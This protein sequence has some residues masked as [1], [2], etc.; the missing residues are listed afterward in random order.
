[1]KPEV[2]EQILIEELFKSSIKKENIAC[3]KLADIERLTG[4]ASTRKYYRVHC[5]DNSFVV[6]LD[7]P[8]ELNKNS[9][10]LIQRF[11]N[12]NGIRVPKIFDRNVEK[13]YLLEEDLGDE[14]LLKILGIINN[15]EQEYEIYKVIIDEL[16]KMHKLDREKLN[17]TII[18]EQSFDK[19]KLNDE[20][21][22]TLKYF[23]GKFLN[24]QDESI[25]KDIQNSFKKVNEEISKMPMVFTHRDF[26]SRNVMVKD[27]EYIVIDFQDAR[28]GIPQYDLVSL[29]EDC[30]YDL[31]ESNREKLKRYYFDEMDMSSLGQGGYDQFCY[32]YDLMLLQRVFKAV[33]SFSYIYEHR[34]DY[35]YV[36]Y[37]G[38]AME[39]L[40]R[41]MLRNSELDNLR[42]SLFNVYYE[43]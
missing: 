14:T 9:F 17:E 12:D 15:E 28:L 39:K 5:S 13:G 18:T 10:V 24:N 43:S 40:R 1:M 30:Y 20:I 29:L 3:S 16:L 35:R 31:T 36:K 2:S 41:T 19:K 38:F 7:N 11:L 23:L 4:D 25:F 37:I 34:K 22:F 33:G 6:C 26:H 21:E 27:G 32:Y 42:R 8:T